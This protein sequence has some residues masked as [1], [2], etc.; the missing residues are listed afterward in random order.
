[1]TTNGSA[2]CECLMAERDFAI[3]CHSLPLI[4]IECHSVSAS[5][6][7]PLSAIDCHSL[8]PL[9]TCLV[10]KSRTAGRDFFMRAGDFAG[11]ALRDSQ[12]IVKFEN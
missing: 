6:R 4:V 9:P 7:L 2:L 10:H 11:K 8:Y 12:K 1:M 5:E 3:Q